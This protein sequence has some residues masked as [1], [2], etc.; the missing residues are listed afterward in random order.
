MRALWRLVGDELALP[1][2]RMTYAEAMTP[3]RQRQAGPA[4]RPWS[5]SSCTDLLRR[6]RRSACSRRRYVGAVVMP[7]GASQSRKE[8][9]GWQDWAKARGAR[10]L[11]YVLVG[12]DG[13]LGGPVAKN[14]SDE[15]AGRAGRARRRAPGDAVF[16]AAGEPAASRRCSARPGSRSAAACGLID[17]AAWSFLW[18]VDAPLFEPV[19]RPSQRDVRRSRRLDRGAPRLHLAA[20]PSGST[21]FQ[22]DPGHALAYAY[23]LVCNGNEIGGGSIRIHRRDVQQR[24]FDVMGLTADEA[25]EKFGFLLDA[26]SY[27]AA[28]ARRHRLRLGPDLRA[29]RRHRLDPRGHRVPEER[30]RLRPAD[31]ARRHRSRPSSARR[32]ASTRCRRRPS[33]ASHRRTRS[34]PDGYR[35]ST[36]RPLVSWCAQAKPSRR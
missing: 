8:L 16:F 1:L 12:E 26:F 21:R 23:D 36:S 5:S 30:R 4:V 28:A 3:L 2:P 20:S 31:R 22:D 7:G 15:R 13:E 14:L 17:E 32:P 9:D 18:V 25:Q 27:G 6:R 35:R 19:G 29:A 11:A 34:V 10:G 24:V 33:L